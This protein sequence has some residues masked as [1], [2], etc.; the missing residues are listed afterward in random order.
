MWR[1]GDQVRCCN[2]GG[3]SQEG[4]QEPGDWSLF[5]WDMYKLFR[6]NTPGF[7]DLAALQAGNAALGVRRAGS[8]GTPETANGRV[9][10]GQFLSNAGG[11][12]RGAAGC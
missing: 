5:S 9:C 3:Y 10:L 8:S 6:A 1:I 2:W 7:E 11:Y 12:P 4:D